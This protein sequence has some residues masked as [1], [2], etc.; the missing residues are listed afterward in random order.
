MEKFSAVIL[1]GGLSSRI[2]QDKGEL[3]LNGKKVSLWT[4]EKVTSLF[5]DVIYATNYPELVPA[6]F[7]LRI[8]TDKVPHL[9][10]VGALATALPLA[11]HDYAFVVAYDMP[12]IEPALIKFL[13]QQAVGFDAC[14]PLVNGKIQPLFAVYRKSC[15]VYINKQLAAG[16][17][18]LTNLFQLAKVKL[19]KEAEVKKYDLELL[20]FFNL[21]SWADYEKATVLASEKL[22]VK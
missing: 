20:S 12:F 9:G 21:N 2:G 5:T 15:L 14:A 8:V 13:T 10:P 1:A 4:T 6:G 11:A 16:Q 18:R 7:N 19:I 3:L 17:Q 22:K